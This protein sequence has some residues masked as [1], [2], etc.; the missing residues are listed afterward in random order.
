M[1]IVIPGRKKEQ[2]AEPPPTPGISGFLNAAEMARIARLVLRSRYV[3]EGNLAGAHR[4]QCPF[5]VRQQRHSGLCDPHLP[6]RPLEQ[7]LPDLPFE[8]SDLRADRRLGHPLPLRR[9]S[10]TAF[11]GDS[12]EILELT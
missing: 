6:T 5:G 4:S 11:L 8:S 10:E 7:R 2:P 3:V 12:D 1:K 9:P